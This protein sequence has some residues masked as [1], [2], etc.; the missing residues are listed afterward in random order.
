MKTAVARNAD[1]GFRLI[2][3]TARALPTTYA[4][5]S[6]RLIAALRRRG[7]AHRTLRRG[8]HGSSSPHPGDMRPALLH[9]A[10][11]HEYVNGSPNKSAVPQR[12]ILVGTA[13][14]S[15]GRVV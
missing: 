8:G 9:R 11:Q 4:A 10:A 3:G 13:T 5:S 2:P 1:V 15:R 12:G 14:R 6:R 7:S